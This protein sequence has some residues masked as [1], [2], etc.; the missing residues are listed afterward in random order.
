MN[1]LVTGGT[2]FIGSAL[3][4]ELLREGHNV[5][6]TTRRRE[7]VWFED[8]GVLRWSP[9][10]LIPPDII[11]NIDAII[12]LAGE[13]I[14]GGRWTAEKKQRIKSSRIDTT[15]AV[16]QS[17]RNVKNSPRTLISASAVGYYGPHGDE[18]ITEETPAGSGFLADVCKAWEAEARKAEAEGVRVVITRIGLVLGPGGGVLS[19]MER[20][21]KFFMGGH[22]GKG[23]QWF[24]WIH[25]ADLIG[26][27]RYILEHEEIRGPVNATAPHPVTNAE[28]SKAIGRVLNRPSWLH[29]PSF[30][31]RLALGEFGEMLLT[32][33]K[34][35][36]ER[37]MKAGYK[38]RYPDVEDALR[39]IY[40]GNA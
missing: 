37:I 7:S 30:A 31:I 21:F 4:E 26:I 8:R 12:N 29:A 32:G 9:P 35:I 16:V 38:F 15:R 36:P 10:A 1:I 19:R 20:P 13:P 11:S 34:V 40:K 18:E 23:R 27:I 14:A 3:T 5:V 22:I 6:I 2:G 17:I 33:Q 25:R 39:S 28:F 24:S